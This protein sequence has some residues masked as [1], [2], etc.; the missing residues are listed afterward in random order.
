MKRNEEKFILEEF[1]AFLRRQ[2][3]FFDKLK[4]SDISNITNI[5]HEIQG[6]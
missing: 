1:V 5:L 6:H 3:Y 4:T 2:Q